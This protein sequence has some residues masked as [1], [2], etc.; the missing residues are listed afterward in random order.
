MLEP[1]TLPYVQ[2]GLIEILLLSIAAGLIGS[3]VVLR[4]LSFYSHAIGTASFPGL[5]L[6][7]GLGFS[8]ALGAF[9]MAGVFTALSTLI[10]RSKRTAADSVT[11]LALVSCLAAGVILAS[12][13]F[14]SGANV[15]TLLFGSLL[16][17]GPNDLWLAGGAALLAIVV[18]RLCAAHWLAKGFDEGSAGNPK[19]G[20]VWFDVALLAV[21]AVTVT[22]ALSAVGALLVAALMVIPA[23]TVRMVTRRVQTLQVGT[24]LLVA[25]EGTLG[26]WLSVKTDAPPGATIA[27]VSGAVFA[28]VLLGRTVRNSRPAALAV[29]ALGLV[30]FAAGCG[31]GG[32]D[33]GGPVKVVATTT[34]VADLVREVGGEQIEVTQILQPN[35]DPHDYEPRPS[36]VE[37]FVDAKLVFKSGGHLDEWTD[38]MIE[39][40][41]SDAAVVDLSANLPVELHAG[42][43]SHEHDGEEAGHEEEHSEDGEETD[44]HWWHD[45]VNAKAAVGEIE[46]AL[47]E[48]DPA[49]K[50]AFRTNAEHY[51]AQLATLNRT[52]AKCF[53]SI[54][55]AERKM[56]TDHDAFNYFASRYGI[57]V[58]GAV[59]PALTTQAQPSAGD[60]AELERTIRDEN[61]KAVFP[62]SSVSKKLSDAVAGDTGA[63][64]E[65]ELFGDSL[66]PE[67]SDGSTYI[68]MIQSNANSIMLGLTGG[69]RGCDFD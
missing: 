62:E 33:D 40:S 64:T 50:S 8:A 34:Q 39:D 3:W 47:I 53:G 45:P 67:D 16:A 35:T 54:P 6:A 18:T 29:A 41:G 7:D 46:T 49:A 58:V 43:H 32:G 5:V 11:A 12:D 56:V 13:V 63:S 52:I 9:G 48:A 57:E 42:E 65:H 25:A 31:S 69:E 1:F 15:D 36:D 19:S 59:I 38:Q 30:L 68:T 21:V 37:A 66:G 17:I 10:A 4:G 26:L 24:V 23:A 44:P 22:A 60:L 61:V 20:S 28:L 27:V 2:E 51:E 14:N 55:A